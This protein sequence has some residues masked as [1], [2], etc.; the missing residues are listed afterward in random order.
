M[1]KSP[2]TF[3]LG[4]TQTVSVAGSSAA[5]SNAFNA[6]TREV[7]VVT[8][9]DSYVDIGSSPTAA[10]TSLIIPAYTVEYFRV[11]SGSKIAF[12]RVGSTTGTARITELT[13]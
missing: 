4:T 3:L 10:S 12:L 13:Q 6:E 5:T 11:P 2:T 9:V 1:N 7:R 8:T